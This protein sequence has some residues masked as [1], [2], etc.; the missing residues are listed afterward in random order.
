V[1]GSDIECLFLLLAFGMPKD[2]WP[3]E[4]ET[5]K[6]DLE[7]HHQWLLAAVQNKEKPL[8][9]PNEVRLVQNGVLWAGK[10][11]VP[12][13]MD[14]GMDRGQNAKRTM[15]YFRLRDLVEKYHDQYDNSEC[16]EKIAIASV[17]LSDLQRVGCR[18][19]NSTLAE[20]VVQPDSAAIKKFLMCFRILE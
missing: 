4:L 15:E 14:I 9:Q 7:T 17:V 5:G 13:N 11:V 12:D 19:V 10:I 18:F 1:L 16:I 20:V 6:L 2:V 3:L 8:A